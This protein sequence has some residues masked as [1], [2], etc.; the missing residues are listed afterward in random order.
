MHSVS[1]NYVGDLFVD[2]LKKKKTM[3]YIGALNTL[4]E[5]KH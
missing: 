4:L 5:A 1:Q 2:L 3:I